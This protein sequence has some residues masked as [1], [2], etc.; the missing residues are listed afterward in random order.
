MAAFLKIPETRIPVRPE[1][2]TDPKAELIR[3]AQQA[4]R[5][6]KEGLTP[7]GSATIGPKYNNLLE[8][9]IQL[10]WSPSIAAAQAPSLARARMRLSE[11]AARVI[12]S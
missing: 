8:E 2:L 1:R 11:L 4:P 7:V 9:Y 3:L 6:I 5:K 12:E 10:N